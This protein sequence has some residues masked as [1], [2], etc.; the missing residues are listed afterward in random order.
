MKERPVFFEKLYCHELFQVLDLHTVASSFV[1]TT[2]LA[3][4]T[5]VGLVEI[6]T[7]YNSAAS[8]SILLTI[9]MLAPES[10]TNSLY[11]TFIV[12]AARKTHLSEIE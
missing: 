3:V 8:R 12:D 5:V 11:S 6:L 10:T 4:T 9:C 7:V 2:P 1:S